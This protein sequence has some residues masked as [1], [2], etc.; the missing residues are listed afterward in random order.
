MGPPFACLE[1]DEV[2]GL[3]RPGGAVT[4]NVGEA[5]AGRPSAGGGLAAPARPAERLT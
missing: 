3:R 2:F 5:H 4:S 1:G